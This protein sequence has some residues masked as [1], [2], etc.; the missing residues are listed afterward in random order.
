MSIIDHLWIIDY[1]MADSNCSPW[2]F[3]YGAPHLW[4]INHQSDHERPPS[5]PLWP[6]KWPTCDAVTPQLTMNHPLVN[7]WPMNAPLVN[8][9][10]LWL[11]CDIKIYGLWQ[12][13]CDGLKFNLLGAQL[14]PLH[15]NQ[16]M[17]SWECAIITGH[18]NIYA[19]ALPH[20]S[21]NAE[22]KA[23]EQN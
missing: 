3:D 15:P 11:A 13:C 10:W 12:C 17:T 9:C 21:A 7:S 5:D 23:W 22:V 16:K 18:P 14:L 2:I 6:W 4:I 19:A 1:W 8:S 20:Y